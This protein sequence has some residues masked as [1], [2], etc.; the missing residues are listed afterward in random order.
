LAQVPGGKT[1]DELEGS[2]RPKD[3]HFAEDRIAGT[4]LAVNKG[5]EAFSGEGYSEVEMNGKTIFQDYHILI[6]P[7]G[8][9]Q[10]K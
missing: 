8:K 6:L 4:T 10:N 7:P 2:P 9:N 5:R 1:L 3:S